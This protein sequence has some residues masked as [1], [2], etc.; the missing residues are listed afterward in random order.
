M[1]MFN[2]EIIS[3][4]ATPE[5]TGLRRMTQHALLR[6]S[7]LRFP[8][9]VALVDVAHGYRQQTYEELWARTNRLANALSGL[10]VQKGDK[11]AFWTEDRLEHVEIWYATSKIGA[12]WTAVN[13]LYTGEEAEYVIVHSDAVVLVFSPLMLD[14][15]Q[16]IKHKLTGV[17]HFVI[18][19]DQAPEG[20]HSYEDL[21]SAAPDREP[22][23]EVS[24]N[25]WDSL[26]YTSGTTG[27]PSGSI[28]THASGL[29]WE[30]NLSQMVGLMPGDRLWAW[31][32]NFHWG[33]VLPPGRCWRREE[34][35]GYRA[36]R[37]PRPSWRRCR[38]RG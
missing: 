15:L 14:R 5:K 31:Y 27:R 23:V 7:V 9:K 17:R 34:P 28:R 30:T 25:D 37:T 38:R 13:A 8:K 3:M 20:I 18:L 6:S 35:G 4:A 16:E 10:G 24:D 11:V 21:L 29:G 26:T 33:G 36:G 12:V 2:E 22:D 19:G 32:P 1:A